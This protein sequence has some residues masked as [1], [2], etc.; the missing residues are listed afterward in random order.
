[1][2]DT[3]FHGREKVTYITVIVPDKPQKQ[4]NAD[5]I[6]SMTN[7]ELAVLIGDNIDCSICKCEAKSEICTAEGGHCYNHWLDWLKKEAE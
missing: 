1:M 4:T 3:T 5:R 7:E 6:R 2:N